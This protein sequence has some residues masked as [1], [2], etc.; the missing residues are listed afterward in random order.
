MMVFFSSLPSAWGENFFIAVQVTIILTLMLY[1]NQNFIYLVVFAPVYGVLVWYLTSQYA[2]LAVLST[3]Q[4][5]V[6]PLIIS[7]RVSQCGSYW[8]K[9]PSKGLSIDIVN[10][11]Y[12][13]FVRTTKHCQGAS[14]SKH[15]WKIT[16]EI[17]HTKD[18]CFTTFSDWNHI[19]YQANV[20]ILTLYR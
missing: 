12:R 1:Y 16:M 7:S 3:L 6:I 8:I 15:H 9:G 10:L 2:S 14:N 17:L 18:N 11:C 4:G 13:L 19:S 5:C 20:Y